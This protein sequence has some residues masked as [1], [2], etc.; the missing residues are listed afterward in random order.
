MSS[1]KPDIAPECSD[2]AVKGQKCLRVV[3]VWQRDC[4]SPCEYYRPGRVRCPKK[5]ECIRPRPLSIGVAGLFEQRGG[6]GFHWQSMALPD[7]RQKNAGRE[8]KGKGRHE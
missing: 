1:E 3:P 8:P 5:L 7:G 2:S 6:I 4:R